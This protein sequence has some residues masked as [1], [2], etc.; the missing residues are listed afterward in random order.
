VTEL[1]DDREKALEVGYAATD[2]SSPVSYE[3]YKQAMLDWSVKGIV[4]NGSLIGAAYFKN[5]EIHVSVLP[6][7]RRRWATK[8][9]LKQLFANHTVTTKVTP[10]HEYMHGILGRLGFVKRG[11]EFVRGPQNGH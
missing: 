10:G 3:Q 2:W 9:V 1:V 6:E 11:E 4:R 7:W 8:G 5:D